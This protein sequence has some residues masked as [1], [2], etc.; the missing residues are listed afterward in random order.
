[1]EVGF[2]FS[3][4]C[5]DDGVEGMD[6]RHEAKIPGANPGGGIFPKNGGSNSAPPDLDLLFPP[7][8][9]YDS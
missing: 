6:G 4:R 8:I 5:G 9:A 3:K 2:V 1:L 7:L